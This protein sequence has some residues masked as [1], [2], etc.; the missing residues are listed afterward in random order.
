VLVVGDAAFRQR[1]AEKMRELFM[2]GA[3]VI[4]VQH[5]MDVIVEMCQRVMWLDKGS[6]QTIGEPLDVVNKYLTSRKLPTIEAKP[7]TPATPNPGVI[8]GG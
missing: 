5:N 2:R 1:C 6:V 3:T 8:S 7:A 4:M